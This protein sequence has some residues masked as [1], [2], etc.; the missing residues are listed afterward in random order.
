MPL[1]P[2]NP[3]RVTERAQKL[4][5][6]ILRPGDIAVD[7]TAGKGRDTACLAQAVGA[8]GH[9]H[10]FDIQP[11]AI[12]STRNL[13]EVAGLLGRVSLHLRSHAE[14][15]DVLTPTQRGKL[16]VAIFNLGYLPGG[17]ASIITQPTSTDRALRDA[18]GH[19]RPGGRLICVAY[20]GHPG[21]PEES[22][23]VLT[24]AE[25]QAQA[26]LHVE[27][28]GYYPTPGKPWILVVNKPAA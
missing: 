19:L 7:G 20:T 18:Y 12:A 13:L 9:V 26:G 2:V 21:G 16:G 14:L 4:A 28:I 5:T 6:E 27:K 3:I 15:A 8:T 11:E 24:F 10:A 22:D 1:A 25:Q 17:D 23:I